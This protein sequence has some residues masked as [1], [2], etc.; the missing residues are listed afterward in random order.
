[1]K[2]T[3]SCEIYI[4]GASRGNPGP[5]GI[6]GVCLNGSAKP[7]WQ[8]SLY[9]GETTNNVAEYSAL[10]SALAEA[11][12]RGHRAVSI[13]TDSELLTR[14]IAGRYQVRTPVLKTYHEWALKL[15]QAFEAAEV[16]HVPREQNRLAD[17]LAGEAVR[18]RRGPMTAE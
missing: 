8:F 12:C 17:R 6:G 13:K 7:L 16:S 1:M 15:M 3:P 4:D 9:I 10:I 2:R 11:L 18:G 14:Q 5:S